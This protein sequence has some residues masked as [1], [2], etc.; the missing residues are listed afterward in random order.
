[1]ET[2]NRANKKFCDVAFRLDSLHWVH[3][4]VHDVVSDVKGVWFE[5]WVFF[6]FLY[7]WVDPTVVGFTK[8]EIYI[9]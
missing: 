1:M 7:K 8:N 6:N 3:S 2:E 9:S 5:T 4:I